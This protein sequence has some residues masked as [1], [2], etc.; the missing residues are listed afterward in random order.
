LKK[1]F[2]QSNREHSSIREELVTAV[3]TGDIEILKSV[4]AHGGEITKYQ[5]DSDAMN[6]LLHYAVKAS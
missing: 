2:A 4:Q 5:N 3:A 6:S 1:T